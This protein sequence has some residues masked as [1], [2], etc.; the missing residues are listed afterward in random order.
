MKP[1]RPVRKD[2]GPLQGP[3][4]RLPHEELVALLKLFLSDTTNSNIED[5]LLR[6]CLAEIA[7]IVNAYAGQK[8]FP[9]FIVDDA[10]STAQL[11]LINGLSTLDSPDQLRAWLTS[12]SRN[13]AV[14]AFLFY[15]IGRAEKERTSVP[16]DVEGPEGDLQQTL[17]LREGREAAQRYHAVDGSE[18]LADFRENVEIRRMVERLL[19]MHMRSGKRRDRDSALWVQT[20]LVEG[21]FK[22]EPIDEIARVRGTTRA[23]VL[24]LLKHDSRALCELYEGLPRTAQ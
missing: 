23:D 15:V 24:H 19:E 21:I 14:S 11:G 9:N 4:R 6:A 5:R 7:I 1:G 17:D 16:L 18:S 2:H 13:A 20:M 10:I 22:G 8:R 3:F 12:V